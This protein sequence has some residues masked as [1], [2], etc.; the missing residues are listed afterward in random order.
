MPCVTAMFSYMPKPMT[1]S[2]AH[3]MLLH[4]TDLAAFYITDL[5]AAL[6]TKGWTIITNDEAYDTPSAQGTLTERVAWLMGVFAPRWFLGNNTKL[7][8]QRFKMRGPGEEIED[9]EN[10]LPQYKKASHIRLTI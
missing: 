10:D 5:V 2:P 9:T 4:E 1:P 8:D 7:A 6:K 3:V